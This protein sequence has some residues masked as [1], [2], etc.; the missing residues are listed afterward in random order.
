MEATA[1]VFKVVIKAGRTE[2]SS[3]FENS[4]ETPSSRRNAAIVRIEATCSHVSLVDF[5]DAS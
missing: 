5:R 1:V 2:I 4:L 3:A